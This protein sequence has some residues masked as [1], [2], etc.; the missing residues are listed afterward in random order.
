M[1]LT[2]SSE[3]ASS[4]DPETWTTHANATRSK[5]G[6]GVGFVL[7]GDGIV[8]VDVDNCVTNGVVEPWA[9]DVLDAAGDTYVE[10]SPSGRG[11]HV[12][13][14]GVLPAGRVL[15]VPGGRVECYGAGRFITVTGDQ[16]GSC[17]R[18]GDL[19]AFLKSVGAV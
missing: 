2:T 11:L 10:L 13:G 12:W 9:Q 16:V 8:C 14:Y 17:R 15:R 1:P 7:N 19:S 18:F 3:A 6:R 4:T 5:V